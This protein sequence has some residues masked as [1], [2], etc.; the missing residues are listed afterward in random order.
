MKTKFKKY[1][2]EVYACIKGKTRFVSLLSCYD[3]KEVKE[4]NSHYF[5]LYDSGEL[6]GDLITTCDVRNGSEFYAVDEPH[7]NES[8]EISITYQTFRWVNRISW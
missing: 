4:G 1:T 3:I 7:T 5:A 8:G 2:V 6:G